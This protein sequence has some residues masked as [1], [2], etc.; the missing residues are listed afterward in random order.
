MDENCYG[1]ESLLPRVLTRIRQQDYSGALQLLQNSSAQATEGESEALKGNALFMLQEYER[2]EQ[3]YEAALRLQPENYAWQD[4]RDKAHRNAIARIDLH[5]PPLYYFSEKT[6]QL[7]QPASATPASLPA[8]LAP[9]RV[10]WPERLRRKIGTALGV[11][12]TLVMD[13][14]T[15]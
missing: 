11:T 12:V 13:V 8:P 4:M 9:R 14:T 5:V 3:A 6:S 2:S 10:L 7:L 15:E 1:S